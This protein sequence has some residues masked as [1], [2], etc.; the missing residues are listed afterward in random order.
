MIWFLL[1]YFRDG[2]WFVI[3]FWGI[4]LRKFYYFEDGIEFIDFDEENENEMIVLFEEG[5]LEMS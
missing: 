2:K 5:G 4:W 3:L 1:F